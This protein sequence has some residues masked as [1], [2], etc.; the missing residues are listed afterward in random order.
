[1]NQFHPS[2]ASFCFK[3]QVLNDLHQHPDIV[4]P[5]IE[6]LML[7]VPKSRFLQIHRA[8]LYHNSRDFEESEILF[9]QL[10]RAD[11]YLIESMDCYSNVLYVRRKY[12]KLCD[13]AHR[14]SI[15]NRYRPETCACIGNYY[16]MKGE[17][18]KA[19]ESFSRALKL[20]PNYSPAWTLLGHEYVDSCNPKAAIEV[21]RKAVGTSHGLSRYQSTRLSSLV[22]IRTSL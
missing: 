1:M 16:S 15:I 20:D 22:W 18:E 17:R 5:L 12:A 21:Y 13:L 2:L 4:G 10:A 19:I 6:D 7:S 9:E 11:P 3:V 14:M 8:I